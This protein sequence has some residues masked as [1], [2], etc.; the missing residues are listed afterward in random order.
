VSRLR[1]PLVLAL[2]AFLAGLIL[3]LRF[4]PPPLLFLPFV[5]GALYGAISSSG[6]TTFVARPGLLLLVAL[7]AAGALA[8]SGAARSAASDC[9][10]T[11]PRGERVVVSGVLGATAMPSRADSRTPLLPLARA[12]L[13]TATGSCRGDVR[14]LLADVDELLPSG[15]TLAAYGSWRTFP[16]PGT[17]SAWP[18]DPRHRGYVLVDS[19]VGLETPRLAAVPALVLRGRT[20]SALQALFPGQ[21][22]I[23]EAL[24]L[25]RREYLDPGVRDRFARAGLAHLLAISGMHVGLLSGSLLLLASA[26]PI[27]R[28]RAILSTIALTAAYLVLIGAPASALRAGTMI[29]LALVAHLLQRPS[30]A[31]TIVA[32]AA[33]AILAFRPLAILDPGF[34][35]SFA[36]V[37]GIFALRQ[38]LLDLT[39]APNVLAMPAR[40]LTEAA[41]VSVAA[42][43]ATAPIAAHHFGLV[44]PVSIFASLPAVPLMSLALIGAAVATALHPLLPGLAGLLADGAGVA[45]VALDRVA[46]IA[47]G[48]PYGHGMLPKPDWAAWTAAGIAAALAWRAALSLRPAM[49]WLSVTGT[50]AAALLAW[51]LVAPAG[52]P[53]L[54]IHFIDV[55][56][57]D[58]VAI[59]TPARRWLLVD[60]GP[61]MGDFDAGAHRVVPY[62]RAQRARSIEALVL[63][64]PHLD[65][66]GGASAV[67]GAFPVRLVIEPGLAVSQI[68]YLDILQR[69]EDSETPWRAARSGRS[70]EI[71]GVHL[72]FLWPDPE[73]IDGAEDANQI[74]A[75]IRLSYGQFAL[76]LPGDIGAPIE[77]LL[78]ERHGE[79]L[80]ADV[81]KLAHHGSATSTSD[82]WLEAVRPELAV[83]SAGR[84]N[85]YGHPA[86]AVMA[87]LE[88]RG[89]PV[90]R[91]DRDGTVVVR[92]RRG[93]SRWETRE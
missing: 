75:V 4:A 31:P 55:G 87:R 59:R 47:A 86:P 57:G 32:G 18:R 45:L 84:G 23:T 83:V 76:I 90:A 49:R 65:H 79:G 12:R 14:V 34:Q 11:L 17:P 25:G 37:L 62:L 80:R 61:L 10:A 29:S 48:I 36:G 92:V 56:Q 33:F 69:L 88:E 38:P 9:R 74:S 3:A 35:L 44:A 46:T 91:T 2:L 19:I 52:P 60:A 63:T 15:T 51:P 7:G 50:L 58:A 78:V 20:E 28:R 13:Q 67:L 53:G 41:I 5:L 89:I 85:R 21:A 72:D 26:L 8:G 82:V 39:P 43:I 73:T 16:T 22:E 40:A 24:L 27:S 70:L 77:R 64:H 68:A 93:G 1:R 71:D 54:E 6:R 81:L 42:F 30:S 66:I